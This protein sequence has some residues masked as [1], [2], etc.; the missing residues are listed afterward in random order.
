MHG[1][2]RPHRQRPHV[3]LV[4]NAHQG[5]WIDAGEF[6]PRRGRSGF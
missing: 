1:S 5:G 6:P 3:E 2:R 4:A